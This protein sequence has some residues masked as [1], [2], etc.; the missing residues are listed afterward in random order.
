MTEL[1]PG[2]R[3]ASTV[4]ETQVVVVRADDP[5]LELTCGGAPM[6]PADE[7]S[8]TTGA[9]AAGHDRATVVGKR[10]VDDAGAVEVLCTRSGAGSLATAGGP[11]ALK[12]A[13]PLPSSD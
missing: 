7:A 12:D 3:L 10:Y 9:P 13:K 8:G 11:L 4:C 2:R 5:A 1:S 6:V